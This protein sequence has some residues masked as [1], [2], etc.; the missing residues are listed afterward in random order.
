MQFR[1][2]FVFAIATCEPFSY[3]HILAMFANV[4]FF[5]PVSIIA[6]ASPIPI[7]NFETV[8]SERGMSELD[9]YLTV[10][11]ERGTK[12]QPGNIH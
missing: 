1:A 9:G 12:E 6:A 8:V 5:L 11:S 4:F 2:T 3:S 7:D 10:V